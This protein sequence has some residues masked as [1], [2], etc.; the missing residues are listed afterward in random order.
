MQTAYTSLNFLIYNVLLSIG[1]ACFFD[2]L[3]ERKYKKLS[4]HVSLFAL[5]QL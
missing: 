1:I 3:L 4:L 5:W 2:S